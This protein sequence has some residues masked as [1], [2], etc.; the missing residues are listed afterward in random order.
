M[1]FQMKVS[2]GE[3]KE[4]STRNDST[5]ASTSAGCKSRLKRLLERQFPSVLRISSSEKL[6]DASDGKGG[7]RDDGCS[8]DPEASSVCLDRMVLSFIEGNN[9]KLSGVVVSRCNRRRCNCFNGNCDSSDDEFVGDSQPIAANHVGEAAEI[10]K[11]LV[12]CT[13][14]TERNLLA[15]VSKIMEKSKI[16][17]GKADCQKIAVEGLRS[18]GYDASVCISRWEKTPF[19]LSGEYEYV[20][21]IVD[22]ERFLLDVDFR[23]EFE[24]ARSTKMYRRVLQLLPTF[25]VGKED[26]LQQI[27]AVAS[28]AAQQSLKKKG[29]HFPPWR[30]TEYMRAKW[31]SPYRRTSLDPNAISGNKIKE[32]V[33]SV[34]GYNNPPCQISTMNFFGEFQIHSGDAED[35]GHDNEA[36][37]K[38]MVVV[39]SW[40]PPVVKPKLAAAATESKVVAGLALVLREKPP[41]P[42]F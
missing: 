19:F 38:I 25:F 40:Q 8:S 28:E 26:R 30:K 20:D 33:M 11:G 14:T 4:S 16:R 24:I 39:S 21:I 34:V 5:R 3:S 23:S 6:A 31:L 37:D 29:L 10:L 35:G 12:P 32:S 22:G 13:S 17:K 7:D 9:E 42:V 2:P 41:S 27:I 1:P 15:D 18:L 36:E